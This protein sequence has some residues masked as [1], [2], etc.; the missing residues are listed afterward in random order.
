MCCGQV[1]DPIVEVIEYWNVLYKQVVMANSIL[2][3]QFAKLTIYFGNANLA[4]P[5]QWTQQWSIA[6]TIDEGGNLSIDIVCD[7][8]LWNESIDRYCR[9]Q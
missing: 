8:R 1:P 4:H 2:S 6:S 9:Q 3:S 7:N 5:G